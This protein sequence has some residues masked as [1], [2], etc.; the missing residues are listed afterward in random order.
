MKGY[1]TLKQFIED[2][3]LFLAAKK[4]D[5]GRDSGETITNFMKN[6]INTR[7]KYANKN[8]KTFMAKNNYN[9]DDLRIIATHD[10]S[11]SIRSLEQFI[12]ECFEVRYVNR[13]Y[14]KKVLSSNAFRSGRLK[15]LYIFVPKS[16][17]KKTE[18]LR[19]IRIRGNVPKDELNVIMR[20]ICK[21]N[22]R[23]WLY[24]LISKGKIRDHQGRWTI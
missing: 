22:W 18:F 10:T 20:Q 6:R 14:Y 13:P 3:S 12:M 2:Y 17:E 9:K 11:R 4:V 15:Q 8:F 5:P 19:F 1:H 7:L 21:K 23:E 24:D 16:I